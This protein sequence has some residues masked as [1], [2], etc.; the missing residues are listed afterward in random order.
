MR[1]AH[2]L[3][4]HVQFNRDRR[5]SLWSVMPSTARSISSVSPSEFR[6]IHPVVSRTSAR[7]TF[8]HHSELVADLIN[9]GLFDL[10]TPRIWNHNLVMVILRRSRERSILHRRLSARVFPV[11]EADIFLIDVDIHEAPQITLSSHT[12]GS[13]GPDRVSSDPIMSH[14]VGCRGFNLTLALREGTQG[15]W[16]TNLNHDSPPLFFPILN[17]LEV[18]QARL[19]RNNRPRHPRPLPES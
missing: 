10:I 9:D 1:F 8:G 16:N 18:H 14:N 6:S 2:C 13:S 17:V 7:R 4:H 19:D 12:A 15:R 5:R 3:F 11:Q